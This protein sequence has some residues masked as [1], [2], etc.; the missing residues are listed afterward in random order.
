MNTQEFSFDQ[1]LTWFSKPLLTVGNSQLSIATVAGLL[2]LIIAFW[3]G[4]KIIES[5]IRRLAARSPQLANSSGSVFAWTRIL[6]YTI[7]IAGSFAALSYMGI[8]LTGLAIL[9]G[10]IGVGVGLGL[11][12]IVANFVSGIILLLEK[13]LKVGDFVELQSGVRGN[14][15]EI[16][17]RYTRITTNDDVDIIVPNNEFTQSRLVNWTYSGR[18]Q[19]LHIP[20]GVAYGTD[21]DK[22]KAAGLRAATRVPGVLNEAGHEPDVWLVKFGDSSLDFELVLWA[23]PELVAKPGST[24]ALFMWVLEDELRD[25]GI[26]IPFPQRDLHVRSGTL[27]VALKGE[28]P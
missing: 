13:T 1:F 14:V 25:A 5:S 12:S 6:R 17:L 3:W 28:S 18:K 24:H 10:A 23:G 11:Q 7:W 20:F 27:E 16:S 4:A 9:G 15:Q 8:D 22:V 2:L 19:R 26:E 21:K